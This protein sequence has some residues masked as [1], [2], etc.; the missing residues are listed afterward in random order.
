MQLVYKLGGV[1]LA[2]LIL[3]FLLPFVYF[4]AVFMTIAFI[5][6]FFLILIS[7]GD[8]TLMFYDKINPDGDNLSG[9]VVWLTGASGG[10]GEHIAYKLATKGCKIVLSARRESELKRV[11]DNCINDHGAKGGDIWIL[12]LD[13]TDFESHR[14]LAQDV[15][16]R[17]GK[18]DILINNGGVSQRS[19][20]VNATLEVTQQLVNVNF[21]GTV[22]ITK[23]VLPHMLSRKSGQ[24]VNISSV[25]GKF[26]PTLSSSYAATK[27]AIQ[28][29]FNTLRAEVYR[30]NVTI[31]NVCPGPVVSNVFT[32]AMRDDIDQP[33][34]KK[35]LQLAE[36]DPRSVMPTERCA[37]LTTVALANNL[38]EAWISKQPVLLFTYV[39][40]YM[41]SIFSWLNVRSGHKRIEAFQKIQKEK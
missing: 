12:P 18:I 33:T 9:K 39:S 16:S 21:I 1:C 35:D 41:P 38:H 30:Q 40:Q 37:H 10:I 2:S 28:G 13:L 24:I 29:Y 22:S 4:I 14:Q 27:H 17:F 19:L 15:I 32:N 11:Q 26:G 5:I 3:L 36:R 31:T 23:S 7:D 34:Y 8:L 6:A 20:G 25:A